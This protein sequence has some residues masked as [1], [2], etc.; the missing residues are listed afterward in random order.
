MVGEPIEGVE[1]ALERHREEFLRIV[2]V[3]GLGIGRAADGR[4]TIEVL[5]DLL[6][7]EHAVIPGQIEG[8]SVRLREVGVPEAE[9]E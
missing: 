7:P 5:V 6:R 3:I 8:F 2:G 1:A 4:P 9:D